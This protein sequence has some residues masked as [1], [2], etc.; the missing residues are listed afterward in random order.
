[1]EPIEAIR[2][3]HLTARSGRLT[4]WTARLRL[5]GSSLTHMPIRNVLRSPRRSLLAAAGVGPAITALV[6]V[7]GMLD[8]FG[9]TIGEAGDE[10]TKGDRDRILV[11]M[12][13]FYRTE[14]PTVAAVT[15]AAGGQT[16]PGLRLPVSAVGGEG[17][18]DLDLL[19]ELVYFEAARWTPT[20]EGPAEVDDGIPP[21]RGGQRVGALLAA[22]DVDGVGRHVHR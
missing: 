7:L 10:L 15:D 19:V 1:M 9:W 2:T 8:S 6:A 4:D 13:T 14:S 12:D 16:D 18:D 21:A 22:V 5:P 11:Q 17:L 20:I 3:G